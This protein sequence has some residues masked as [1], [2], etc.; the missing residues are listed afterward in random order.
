MSYTA[1]YRKWRPINFTEVVGQD[2]IVRTL[3][4]QITAKRIGHAYL[5]C[6]T[7]GTGK[8]T[9]AKIFA[10]AVNCESPVEGSPCNVCNTCRNLLEGKSM[11]VIEID[12]ASNNG[13]DNIREIREEVRYTPTEGHY[14]VYII[15]E[16]HMLSTGAFNALLKT[17]EEPPAHIIFILATTEPHKIPATILSRVQR[18]DLK[19]IGIETIAETLKHY[20][21]EEKIEAEER[22]IKYVAK[23][24]D[25]SMRDALSILDQC[26]AFYIGETITLE[27]VLEVLGAVDHEVFIRIMD[28]IHAKAAKDCMDIIDEVVMQGRDLTQFLVDCVSHLR[29]M[30][31]IK[32]M[33]Q[34]E[35]VLDLSSESIELLR[36]QVKDFDEN[37]L[38]LLINTFSELETRIK[39]ATAKR[40]L[41]EVE[42][43]RLCQPSMNATNAG[44]IER[45]KTIEKKLE[46][47][48]FVT[49]APIKESSKEKERTKEQEATAK[50]AINPDAFP[51]DIKLAIKHWSALVERTHTLLKAVLRETTPFYM[52]NNELTLITT[53]DVEKNT[54]LQEENLS[55]INNVLEKLHKKQ[56]KIVVM[57]ENEFNSKSAQGSHV[58]MKEVRSVFDDIASKINF[59]IEIQ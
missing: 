44:L 25:G 56:F 31:V 32:S 37:E 47:G 46:D 49:E 22:A 21:I 4:N 42:L 27:K 57:D 50:A 58:T 13:V 59:D 1:L 24:A 30:L 33:D 2:A 20:M 14:K 41:V 18:Y 43:I 34:V 7:R 8:T 23:V 16:V 17:L 6:G 53:N 29:N 3:T 12:A 10:R 55:T 45:V 51:E 36:K 40:I 48:V 9:M 5:F 54:L 28:A 52:D 19:R 35:D 26:I 38:M 39:Y 15:D 11:N